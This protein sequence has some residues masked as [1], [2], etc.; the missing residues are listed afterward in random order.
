VC[1]FLLHGVS[2]ESLIVSY[3]LLD[4]IC[5][6]LTARVCLVGNHARKV[7]LLIGKLTNT[8]VEP[9]I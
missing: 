1:A 4:S 8:L 9:T 2:Y 6:S 5:L 7:N 3:I